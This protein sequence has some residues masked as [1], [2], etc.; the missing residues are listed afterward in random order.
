MAFSFEHWLTAAPR[1]D[2]GDRPFGIAAHPGKPDPPPA[3]VG[4]LMAAH[5]SLLEQL[6]GK[7]WARC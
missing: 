2:C 7:V 4:A 5:Y 3:G 1:R 6:S